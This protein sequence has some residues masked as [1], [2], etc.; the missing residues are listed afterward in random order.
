MPRDAD[1]RLVQRC[2]E[3]SYRLRLRHARQPGHIGIGCR[4][5]D[6]KQIAVTYLV[7]IELTVILTL[8]VPVTG[9]A[10]HARS[11]DIER[12]QSV[13]HALIVRIE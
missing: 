4:I 10:V 11:A 13:A 8:S 3:G 12:P 7:G 6:N 5:I 9:M 2:L 1:L